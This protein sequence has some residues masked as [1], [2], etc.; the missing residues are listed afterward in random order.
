MRSTQKTWTLYK[1]GPRKELVA[2]DGVRLVWGRRASLITIREHC[3]EHGIALEILAGDPP[4]YVPPPRTSK[5]CSNCFQV[6]P[7]EAF[8]RKLRAHQSRCKACNAEVV[9][10]Y[11]AR[12]RY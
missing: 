9:R 11:Y 1:N 7:L 12:F 5:K 6:K 8:Y 3:D 2:E 10:G 4:A